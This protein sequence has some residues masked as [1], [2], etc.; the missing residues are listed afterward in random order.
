MA[1]RENTILVRPLDKASFSVSAALRFAVNLGQSQELIQPFGFGFAMQLKGHLWQLGQTRFGFAFVGGHSRFLDSQKYEIETGDPSTG[2]GAVVA[3]SRPLLLANTD[4][5][6]GPALQIP[7]GQIFVELELCAG[8]SILQFIRPLGPLAQ[9]EESLVVVAP[10]LRPSL[11]VGIP[12]RSN[13]GIGIGLAFE[14]VWTNTVVV[15]DPEQALMQSPEE[16]EADERSKV[17]DAFL[18]SYATYQV[19]F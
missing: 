17:F 10:M 7:L 14:K 16:V 11:G 1:P 2:V 9:Q 12:I 19:W 5:S 6:V 15:T 13:Q 4:F 18:Y 3:E 8:L